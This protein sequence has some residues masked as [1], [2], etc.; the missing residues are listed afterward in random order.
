MLFP[1][2]SLSYV[3]PCSVDQTVED[4]HYLF[5]IRV[6]QLKNKFASLQTVVQQNIEHSGD[7]QRLTDCV[8]RMKILN[9]SDAAVINEATSS[10]DSIFTVLQPYWSFIDYEPLEGIV[11]LICPKINYLMEEY[12][13]DIKQ[14]CQ[15]KVSEV[16]P[17]P[18]CSN[19]YDRNKE[20]LSFFVNEKE[21][22]LLRVKEL[23]T[24]IAGIF[25]VPPFHLLLYCIQGTCITCVIFR[26][27]G[28]QLFVKKLTNE[29]E[30]EFR[31]NHITVLQFQ[32]FKVCISEEVIETQPRAGKM[33]TQYKSS[34]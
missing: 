15:C 13:S 16:P 30:R 32:R 29:Q 23:K 14:L 34:H 3:P 17:D 27:L 8:I 5:R 12:I 20:K 9:D 24:I 19:A 31:R 6:N 18:F 7:H 22:S 25:S 4:V 26:S 2:L 10:V 1:T 11:V 33:H 28:K 21:L